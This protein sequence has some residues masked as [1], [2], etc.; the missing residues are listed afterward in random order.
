VAQDPF[1]KSLTRP[2]D[3]IF[4]FQIWF[5]DHYDKETRKHSGKF[6]RHV[7]VEGV[8]IGPESTFR[9]IRDDLRKNGFAIG[10][11]PGMQ[12]AN[13]LDTS[14]FTVGAKSDKIQRMEVWVTH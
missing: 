11:R 14:I 13:K 6:D 9:G 5:D 2:A 1:A 12:Y 7:Q 4:K 3:L 8:E 10:D